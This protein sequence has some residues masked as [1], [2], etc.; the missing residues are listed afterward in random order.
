MIGRFLRLTASQFLFLAVLPGCPA[1]SPPPSP[2]PSSNWID[3]RNYGAKGDGKTDD[4]NAILAAINTAI[5]GFG[6]N[7]VYFPPTN[8]MGYLIGSDFKLPFPGNKWIELY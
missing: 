5:Q 6:T 4:K 2:I 7:V 3:V 8:G 1:Q